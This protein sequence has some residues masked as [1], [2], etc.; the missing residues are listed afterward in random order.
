M[1]APRGV[2]LWGIPGAVLFVLVVA[3][4][5]FVVAQRA[6]PGQLA[7]EHPPVLVAQAVEGT[8]GCLGCHSG[9][10]AFT[11][12]AMMVSI[13]ALGQASG[14][15][16]GCVVCHGG[17]PTATVAEEAHARAPETL[18]QAGGPELFYPDPGNVWIADRTCGQCHPGYAE[19]V[20]MSLMNT[21]AGKLQGN[22]WSWGLQ[23]D[24]TVVWG[25][26]SMV[27][28]DGPTPTVGTD[29]YR[30]YMT[31]FAAE[32]PDQMPTELTQVPQVDVSEIPE[33]PNQAGITY[34]RQQCQ[35]CHVGVTGRERRGDY[36]GTGCSSCHVP[37]SNEGFYQ[38]GDPTIPTDLPGKLLVHRLQST[39]ERVVQVGEVVY[40]GIPTESCNSCHNRG[41]RI[42][43]SYQG[44]M[45]FP[46][47]SPYNATGEKQPPLHTKNYLF[48]KDDL[49]HQIESR[50]GNP[51]GGCCAR[52]ATPRSTCT[53]TATSSA[54]P[55]RRSRSSARTATERPRRPHGSCRSATA[56]SSSNRSRT[57]RAAWPKAC[58]R[59]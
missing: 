34:S 41:K 16:E 14:D 21:E 38:G 53:A 26:Y 32:H 48:I 10:E 7:P 20:Q 59:S 1:N 57:N 13:Q 47:G 37:Y 9:I 6:P 40:S 35:R 54:Q 56:R 15:P 39:R 2:T 33:H 58:R 49:H 29:A 18:M 50:P 8:E 46:Y 3:L 23:D 43:V 25:N 51:E 30:E 44:I 24:H 27:D 45:E 11:A 5:W 42:G 19:R 17:D 55:W 36:R 12:G 4:T 31:A 28:E 52:T 22:F